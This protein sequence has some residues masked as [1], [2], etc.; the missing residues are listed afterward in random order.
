MKCY[1][2]FIKLSAFAYNA[3]FLTCLLHII[4]CVVWFDF[5]RNCLH[6]TLL[7]PMHFFPQLHVPD[8]KTPTKFQKSVASHL[9]KNDFLLSRSSDRH[10]NFDYCD[11]RY[12]TR[13][14]IWNTRVFIIFLPQ[15]VK[16]SVS[17]LDINNHATTW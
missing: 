13:Y 14:F 5:Q 3:L 16:F 10:Y 9:F 12:I 4:S 17:Q 15:I 11:E 7:Q 8:N 6:S 2:A 1:I